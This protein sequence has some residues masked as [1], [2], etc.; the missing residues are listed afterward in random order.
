MKKV[1]FLM[2]ALLLT[3]VVAMAQGPMDPEEMAQRMTDRMV[4]QYSL[5]DDQ[6]AKV[7]AVTKEFAGKMM[8][9]RGQGGQP[10][11]AAMQQ[12][13]KTQEEYTAKLKGI[14]TADQ[15][16]AYEKDQ[17]ERRQRFGGGGGPR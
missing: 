6:A 16:K 15:F 7:L 1:F 14:L 12:F 2:S 11:E 4:E 5:N 17:A 3:T 13:R 9:A 8:P 10:D